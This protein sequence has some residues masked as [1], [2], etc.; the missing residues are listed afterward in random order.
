MLRG[1]VI[2]TDVLGV[3]V[4]HRPLLAARPVSPELAIVL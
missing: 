4:A 3:V 2:T 1:G